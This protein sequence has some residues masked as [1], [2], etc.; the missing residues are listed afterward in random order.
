MILRNKNIELRLV[1]TLMFA[2]A[3]L[4]NALA[5]LLPIN[6]LD[7][8]QVSDRYP[9]LFTPAGLTFSI[10]SVIYFLLTG[11]LI[12]SWIRKN[13]ELFNRILP[14]FIL[15]CLLNMTWIIVWHY[16][17]TGISV[18]VMLGLLTVLIVI[19]KILQQNPLKKKRE[20]FWIVLPFT[21]Y[22][23]WICVATIA[24]ISALL[25]S[26]DWSGGF[27]SSEGWTVVMMCVA[28]A[29]AVKITIDFKVPFFAVVVIWALLGIHIRWRDGQHMLIF[30][31]SLVL[32]T[33]LI[34]TLILS[35]GPK[36]RFA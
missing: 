19:F 16:L 15:S 32:I 3:L 17:L 10:W 22:L 13:S 28:A 9:S 5:N 29:L 2:G 18:L 25:V 27:L 12:F 8:G 23:S 14:W 6:G 33:G 34:I 36:K 24:N 30:Y 11:F 21:L 31:S 4:V 35:S 20:R 7:T 1:A 26:I